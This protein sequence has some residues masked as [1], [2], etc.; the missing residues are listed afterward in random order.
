LDRLD[1]DTEAGP[2][3][4]R[5]HDYDAN[6]N[7]LTDGAGT[8]A[9]FTPNSDRVATINGVNVTLDAAGNLTSDGTYKYLWNGLGQL[10][11]LRKAD[12]TLI[13]T[14]YYDY[15]WLRTRKV[16]TAAAPQGAGTTFYH[17]DQEGHLVGETT[18][19]NQPQATYVWNGDILTGYITYNPRTV[20]TV[21]VDHLGSPFQI[22]T[23]AGKI[24]WRWE[25]DGYGRTPPNE[26]V[27]GDGKRLTFNLRYLGMY[28]DQE[29][30]L[31]YNWHRYYS[32]RIGYVS[33][34]PIGLA[35]GPNLYAYV[36]GNPLSKTDPMGLATAE[37]AEGP[38]SQEPEAYGG[39]SKP[40]KPY[41]SS[42]GS[43][44]ER[45]DGVLKKVCETCVKFA[46]NFGMVASSLC[47]LEEHRQCVI[48]SVENG[49]SAQDA[50][51]CNAKLLT[52]S[53]RSGGGRGGY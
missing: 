49:A 22:R 13:A 26:D 38:Y 35:G 4:A 29:S 33:P 31:F 6:G 9:T 2:A 14:Y 40:N 46:C 24:I 39:I 45:H 8:T 41:N 28:A 52:C 23:L 3:G 19:G 7:R 18:P 17:Y 51:K 11:E 47:C 30:G 12:N 15:R 20:Y 48:S 21:Q 10:G 1:T 44:C 5:N 42:S 25:S 37:G 50:A 27:D 36:G 53:M 16:T 32:P 34:D 43:L